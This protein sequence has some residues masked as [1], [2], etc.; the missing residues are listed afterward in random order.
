MR[1]ATSWCTAICKGL[2]WLTRAQHAC[3]GRRC[4]ANASSRHKAGQP[5]LL[6]QRKE[7]SI[8]WAPSRVTPD[9]STDNGPAACRIATASLSDATEMIGT[10]TSFSAPSKHQGLP[11]FVCSSSFHLGRNRTA[12]HTHTPTRR[13]GYAICWSRWCRP[14]ADTSLGMLHADWPTNEA[15]GRPY[16]FV[17]SI[18]ST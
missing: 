10:G 2:F 15:A 13:A 1:F 14:H 12:R 11:A 18:Q 16:L 7:W 17:A 8:F 3:I 4:L 5:L 9:R 6:L